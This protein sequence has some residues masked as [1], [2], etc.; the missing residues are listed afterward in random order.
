MSPT[1][2]VA[3]AGNSHQQPPGGPPSIF[4][5]VP[6]AR[7]FLATPTRGAIAVNITTTEKWRQE[8]QQK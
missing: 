4:D 1:T 7:I 3:T 2:V 8:F 6:A 5:L